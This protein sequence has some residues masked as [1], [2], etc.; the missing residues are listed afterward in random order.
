MEQQTEQQVRT[1]SGADWHKDQIKVSNIRQKV[2][3]HAIADVTVTVPV[4]L[5]QEDGKWRLDEV[6]LDDEWWESVDR[7]V[8]AIQA[9]RAES[10]RRQMDAIRQGLDRFYGANGHIPQATS[11]VELIDQLN[12][13][14]LDSVIRLDGWKSPF[15]YATLGP[16]RYV[17]TSPGPD[18][19]LGTSDDIVAKQ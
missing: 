16:D 17:L 11:F 7:I 2:G 9:S 14:F 13:R 6:R 4:T 5:K 3:G 18:R 8:A 1:L 19:K 12:P 15:A 10:T